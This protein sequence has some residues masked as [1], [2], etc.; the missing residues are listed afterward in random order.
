M[1]KVYLFTYLFIALSWLLWDWDTFC[2]SQLFNLILCET[3]NVKIK[4]DQFC[5]LLY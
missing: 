5:S 3:Q 2:K 4:F 1:S